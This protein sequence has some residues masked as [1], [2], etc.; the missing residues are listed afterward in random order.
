[1]VIVK[2][3]TIKSLTIIEIWE[4][5]V[6]RRNVLELGLMYRAKTEPR[7]SLRVYYKI[8]KK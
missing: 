4:K 7:E 1:M 5:S 3:T 8:K 6:Y 2:T